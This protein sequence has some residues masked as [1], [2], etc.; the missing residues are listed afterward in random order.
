VS[1]DTRRRRFLTATTSAVGALGIG[2]AAWPFIAAWRPSARARAEFGPI[3]VD[4]AKL[5]PG[6]QITLAWRGQPV[7]VLHRTPEMVASLRQTTASLRDPTS[8]V[9]SQQPEYAQNVGRSLTPEFFVTVALC[10]HLGCVPT[11]RSDR[12]P[13]DLGSAWPGGYFCP[14][15]GSRFDLAG[16]VF[17]SVPAPTNLLVPPHRF[18]AKGLLE[19]GVAPQP[20]TSSSS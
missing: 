13:P 7:W 2:A 4:V 6:Q 9:A 15:H 3:V 14:C 16:R 20:D 8:T 5:E 10:T 17:A 1:I 18:I 11:Y 19:I 12:A